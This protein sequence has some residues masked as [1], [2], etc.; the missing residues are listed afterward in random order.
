MDECCLL[1]MK[2]VLLFY[3]FSTSA[4]MESE[5]WWK[6]KGEEW[7][8]SWYGQQRVDRSRPAA[9][10]EKLWQQWGWGGGWVLYACT[11]SKNEQNSLHT[12]T[13]TH[14]KPKKQ[15]NICIHYMKSTHARA[16]AVNPLNTSSPDPP[17][18]HW[19]LRFCMQNIY[20]ASRI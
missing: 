12:H 19:K 1:W 14:R 3:Y 10:K 20:G 17:P 2:S 8:S 15:Q 18:S 6:W 7:S 13:G 11:H 9:D 16:Y 4:A 5:D